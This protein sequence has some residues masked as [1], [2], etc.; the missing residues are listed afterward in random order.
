MNCPRCQTTLQM[1]II[2]E[3]NMQLEVDQC[4]T[5]QGIWFDQNE[6][7]VIEKVIEPV[8]FE[9][10]KIPSEYDQLTALNCPKCADH[11]RMDKA[12]HPRDE[13]VIMD[14]CHHCNGIWLDGGELEAIQKENWLTSIFNLI[15][16]M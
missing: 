9:I 10:R 15:K 13:Q 12:E 14:V 16:K 3:Q 11:P 4:S 7:Q 5:C 8:F 1:V 2:P 6:L